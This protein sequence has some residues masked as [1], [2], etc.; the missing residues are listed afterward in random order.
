MAW[1]FFIFYFY[2]LYYDYEKLPSTHWN[3]ESDSQNGEIAA[4]LIW[5]INNDS[6]DFT[7]VWGKYQNIMTFLIS[8]NIFL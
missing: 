4:K 6:I 3:I 8:W 7:S 2:E 5:F 1:F